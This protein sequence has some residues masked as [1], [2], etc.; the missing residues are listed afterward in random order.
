VDNRDLLALHVFGDVRGRYGALHGLDIPLVFG[1]IAAR[2]SL[3]GAG[4]EAQKMADQIGDAFIAFARTGNPNHAGI[5]TWQT[6]D[7]AS[8]ATMMFDAATCP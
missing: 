7:I 4:V 1:N 6:Y 5:P 8:R 3:T 2:G